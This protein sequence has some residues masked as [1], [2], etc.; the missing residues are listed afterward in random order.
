MN[1]LLLTSSGLPED[2]GRNPSTSSNVGTL[3]KKVSQIEEPH[4]SRIF[5][6]KSRSVED[7]T[8]VRD[9]FIF[10][11]PASAK[12]YIPRP[13]KKNTKRGNEDCINQETSVAKKMKTASVQTDAVEVEKKDSKTMRSRLRVER[14]QLEINKLQLQMAVYKA[15]AEFYEFKTEILHKNLKIKKKI[16]KKIEPKIKID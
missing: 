10:S 1:D 7:V 14:E 3:N 2:F 9:E 15:K 16:K 12:E 11:Q 4:C 8:K 13:V 5:Q 6:E